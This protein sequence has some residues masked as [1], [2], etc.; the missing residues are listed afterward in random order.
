[1]SDPHGIDDREKIDIT[2]KSPLLM[3]VLV[4]EREKPALRN[5]RDNTRLLA[6]LE[7]SKTSLR[8]DS[9]RNDRGA[10]GENKI[11]SGRFGNIVWVEKK[12]KLE[13]KKVEERGKN[14]R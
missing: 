4:A 10:C 13:S 11:P 2:E 7:G 3:N 5:H 14:T 1:M 6:H 9:N 8:G 12:T